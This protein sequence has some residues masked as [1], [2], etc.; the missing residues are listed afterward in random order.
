M[1]F[2]AI[3][4]LVWLGWLAASTFTTTVLG[5][6]TFLGIVAWL[7]I[8]RD[9]KGRGLDGVIH[10]LIL[11]ALPF[12]YVSMWVSWYF[13]NDYNVVGELLRTYILR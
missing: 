7:G 8:K 3:A 5:T 11:I 2:I 4:I 1:Q 13:L 6:V 9:I 10:M 12:F